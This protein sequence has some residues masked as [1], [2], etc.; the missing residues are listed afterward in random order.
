MNSNTNE[1][2]ST[3][4]KSKSS[5]DVF[6]DKINSNKLSK[7]ELSSI[8]QSFFIK[9]VFNNEVL[10]HKVKNNAII[11]KEKTDSFKSSF[12]D[13]VSTSKNSFLI[14]DTDSNSFKQM[15]IDFN[16]NFI[17]H[18]L[19]NFKLDSDYFENEE[20]FDCKDFSQ[21][22]DIKEIS[23]TN[24][25]I[26]KLF[27]AHEANM[28]I[29]KSEE[30]FSYVEKCLCLIKSLE[31]FYVSTSYCNLIKQTM[32]KVVSNIK[33]I[34]FDNNKV[35]N[36]DILVLDMDETLLHTDYPI[37]FDCEYDFLINF[38]DEI[39]G[40]SIRP[41]LFKFLEE[42]SKLF[43]LVLYSA[44][45]TDYVNKII[46]KLEINKFFSM[47]LCFD[48]T[49]NVVNKI[50]IKDLRIIKWLD[51]IRF[52]L[53]Y[54]YL[55]EDENSESNSVQNKASIE[56][57]VAMLMANDDLNFINEGS[58]KFKFYKKEILI[59]DN[60]I[61]SFSNNLENGILIEDYFY[62][63]EDSELEN[64]NTLLINLVNEKKE[65]GTLFQTQIKQ[66]FNYNSIIQ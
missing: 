13:K 53:N 41:G 51:N 22:N 5:T 4:R 48:E 6:E 39:M 44:G 59:V 50:F 28:K 61:F 27:E 14:S 60:N 33:Y 18:Q 57:I 42:S 32:E 52:S 17:N 2:F 23:N 29:E 3:K 16:F 7:V 34:V 37:K 66:I 20:S 26:I 25:I 54:R 40:I 45:K 10:T 12:D 36:K 1:Q 31:F 9:K 8:T 64:L 43:D 30:N 21:M 55:F 19:N 35:C 62:D 63:K 56:E 38:G 49:V 11:N 46:S 24:E 65:N 15:Q 47:T 58:Y